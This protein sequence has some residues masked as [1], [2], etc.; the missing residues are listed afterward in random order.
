VTL[1]GLPSGR[2]LHRLAPGVALP[3]TPREDGRRMGLSSDGRSLAVVQSA[4][5]CVDIFSFETG[6]RLLR[7]APGVSARNTTWSRDDALLGVASM[8]GLIQVWDTRTGELRHSFPQINDAARCVAFHPREPL[9][10][11]VSPQRNLTLRHRLTGRLLAEAPVDAA[12]VSFNEDGS[13]LGPVWMGGQIGWLETSVSPCFR[14]VSIGSPHT[15]YWHASFSPDGGVLAACAHNG[16]TFID[17]ATLAPLAV[18]TNRTLFYASFDPAGFIWTIDNAGVHRWRP[19]LSAS[20]D[21]KLRKIETRWPGSEWRSLDF[22]ADCRWMAGANRQ[23]NRLVVTP[24]QSSTNQIRVGPHL[25]ARWAAVDREARHAV[26]SSLADNRL[27]IWDVARNRM[28]LDLPCGG[29][30]GRAAFSPD[31]RWLT[32]LGEEGLLWSVGQWTNAVATLFSPGETALGDGVFSADNRWLAVVANLREIHLFD[33]ASARRVA[34]FQAPESPG[35]QAIALSPDG[36]WLIA[37]CREGWLQRW[38]LAGL[39]RELA[40]L[41]LEW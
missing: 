21:L 20:L 15:P 8:G 13:R 14:S 18:R 1:R 38:D 10:A 23:M 12:D 22:S 40:A 17:T 36:R 19:N 30:A 33:V 35:I 6:E 26:T 28:C 16:L 9:L 3:T 37:L 34:L 39:R 24:L 41:S 11:A 5:N 29:Y 25:G 7:V 32:T 31:G 27:K 4:T 2:V